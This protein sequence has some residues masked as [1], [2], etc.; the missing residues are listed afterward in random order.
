MRENPKDPASNVLYNAAAMANLEN[1]RGRLEHLGLH[2]SFGP[3]SMFPDSDKSAE[4]RVPISSP[5]LDEC[6]AGDLLASQY[7]DRDEGRKE[8]NEPLA[9]LR[10]DWPIADAMNGPASGARPVNAAASRVIPN[11]NSR[12][13]VDAAVGCAGLGLPPAVDV[14]PGMA[15]VLM[16]VPACHVLGKSPLDIQ[17]DLGLP[18][19]GPNGSPFW[20]DE[21]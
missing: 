7:A 4:L 8:F 20:F 9:H 21:L 5:A 16:F 6:I 13:L 12:L 2:C 3:H 17:G 19:R 18:W 1:A 10:T 11:P 14:P 15:V